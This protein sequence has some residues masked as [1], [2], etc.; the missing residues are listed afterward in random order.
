MTGGPVLL[1]SSS[2]QF[3]GGGAASF[4]L[5]GGNNL[6]GNIAVG[7]TVNV[8][9]SGSGNAT[10][11]A[12]GSF[13]NAGTI[14]LDSVGGQYANIVGSGT[15]TNT[16]SFQ[17]VQGAGGTR[18]IEMNFIN[19]ASG[20]VTIDNTDTRQ[21][22][23]T[24]MTNNG[25]FQMDATAL[26]RP[27]S[28]S[29][30]TQSASGIFEAAVNPGGPSNSSFSGDGSSPMALDGKLIVD[31]VGTA[32]TGS[33]W[34]IITN[35]NRSGTFSSYTMNAQPYSVTYPT[36]GVT[37]TAVDKLVINTT[38]L[39]NA[40]YGHQY[41]QNLSATGGT[42]P[43]SSWSLAS[44]SLPG[45]LTLSPSGT[46]SGQVTGNAGTYNFTVQISDSTFPVQ[47]ATQALSIT[48]DP[49]CPMSNYPDVVKGKP[50]FGPSSPAADYIWVDNN[51]LFHLYGTHASSSATFLTGK[52]V[53]S[54]GHFL[55]FAPVDLENTAPD[56]DTVSL[57]AAK[58]VLTFSFHNR[59][60]ID[61]VVFGVTCD[62]SV[63]FALVRDGDPMPPSQIWVGA[64]GSHPQSNPF[65]VVLTG[66]A[67]ALRRH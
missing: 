36:H 60:D 18:Y 13:T 52:V 49:L 14:L 34:N 6:S 42:P 41:S 23:N 33:V 5:R 57:N 51:G 12:A 58:T 56:A 11:N 32:T 20:F 59:G 7:Q 10:T 19:A 9:G 46:I 4:V 61:G 22:V 30:F 48:V 63:G 16:G 66:N 27:T 29:S 39:P 38:S 50:G 21:D 44:G 65:T 1:V 26:Y 54:T 3:G 37:L 25:T 31:T 53:L 17:S 47:T 43:L 67:P 45:G 64:H 28:G 8:Q 62:S 24:T 35:V 55:G 15:L 2:L 40:T